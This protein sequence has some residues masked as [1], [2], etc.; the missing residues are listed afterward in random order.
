MLSRL[1]PSQGG[2]SI[3]RVMVDEIQPAGLAAPTNYYKTK[4]MALT[5][6]GIQAQ[7]IDIISDIMQVERTGLTP[8]T[9]IR[10]DLHADSMAVLTLT[11][12]LDSVFD[13]Q[14]DESRLPQLTTI[15]DIVGY[16]YET[17]QAQG[18][19]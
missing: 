12:E 19:T 14:C 8:D 15:G 3:P 9:D 18:A 13:M 17:F 4:E 6:E 10:R 5:H 7:V 2:C 16:I 11:I 1:S